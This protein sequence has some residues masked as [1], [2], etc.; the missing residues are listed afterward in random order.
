[1]TRTSNQPE[2]AS[3]FSVQALLNILSPHS[4]YRTPFNITLAIL[5]VST[6]WNF[7]INLGPEYMFN[8]VGARAKINRERVAGKTKLG[9]ED[10]DG[11]ACVIS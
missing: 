8:P 11:Q 3:K 2:I 5:L 10:C 1:M 6:N 4:Q 7:Q 9:G